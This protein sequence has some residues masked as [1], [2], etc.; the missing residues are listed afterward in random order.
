MR[1]QGQY[2]IDQDIVALARQM[3]VIEKYGQK[4]NNTAAD[5]IHVFVESIRDSIAKGADPR[6]LPERS[7]NVSFWV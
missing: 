1:W 2:V 3:A 5:V 6:Q 4:F 7:V